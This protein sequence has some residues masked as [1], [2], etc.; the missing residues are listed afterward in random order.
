[1]FQFI[2]ANEGRLVNDNHTNGYSRS[3]YGRTGN[4]GP[5]KE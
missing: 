1:M 5:A 4:G 2:D 3:K